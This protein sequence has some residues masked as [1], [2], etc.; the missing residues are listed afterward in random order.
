MCELQS[1]S[2]RFQEP[3]E[4]QTLYDKRLDSSMFGESI[5]AI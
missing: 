3:N 4:I 1:E 5:Q 2:Q